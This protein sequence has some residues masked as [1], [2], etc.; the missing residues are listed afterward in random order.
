MPAATVVGAAHNNTMP[1]GFEPVG[2]PTKLDEKGNA[3]VANSRANPASHV[4]KMGQAIG[5][6]WRSLGSDGV[7]P[8]VK[9]AMA[10]PIKE[11][12]E[13]KQAPK[14]QEPELPKVSPQENN[15]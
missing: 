15:V 12:V 13:G 5:D 4:R 7:D 3:E 14:S 8:A 9:H 2:E 11:A 10:Q 6:A 1:Y